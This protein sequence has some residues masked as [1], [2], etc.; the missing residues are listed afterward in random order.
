MQGSYGQRGI[1]GLA[2]PQANPTA[3]TEFRLLLPT[4]VIPATVRLAS[5]DADPRHRLRDYFT[6]LSTTLE[7]FDTLAL[8]AVGLACTGSSYVLGHAEAERRCRESGAARGITVVSAASAIDRALRH[9]G[10]S[11]LALL[12]PYPRWLQDLAVDYWEERGYS[13]V[14]VMSL[15]LGQ[16]DTRSIYHLDPGT[17]TQRIR[18]HWRSL[19]ADAYLITGT[20]MPSLG[21][22]DALSED[23]GSPVLSST[24][25]L[26]WAC[27]LAGEIHPGERSAAEGLPLLAGWSDA[28]SRV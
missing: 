13:V 20:G 21:L 17:H 5:R 28:L 3:E 6:D 23:L 2:T 27:L 9:L 10:A 14:D 25:C 11:R 4:G 18:E 7:R 1:I 19:S 26:A 12:S 22:I 15:A 24:L 16:G 8:A